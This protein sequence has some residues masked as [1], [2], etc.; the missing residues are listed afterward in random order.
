[1]QRKLIALGSLIPAVIL[2]GV[3]SGQSALEWCGGGADFGKNCGARG[4]FWCIRS[5]Q[6]IAY[7]PVRFGVDTLHLVGVQASSDSNMDLTGQWFEVMPPENLQPADL[8][9]AQLAKRLRRIQTCLLALLKKRCL[10]WRK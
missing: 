3:A 8:H 10:G 9:S 2:C 5:K 4:I 6:D 7:P 1:M